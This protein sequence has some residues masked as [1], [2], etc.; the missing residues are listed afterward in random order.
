MEISLAVLG[1]LHVGR[2]TDTDGKADSWIL[3]L[4]VASTNKNKILLEYETVAKNL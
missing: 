2:W 3:Y 4:L 1:W